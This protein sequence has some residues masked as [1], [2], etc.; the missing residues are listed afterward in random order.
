MTGIW[1]LGDYKYIIEVIIKSKTEA[2]QIL[3]KELILNVIANLRN[4][5]LATDG[6]SGRTAMYSHR[7]L[8]Q[9]YT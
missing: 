1:F 7:A 2:K 6:I 3:S 8:A 9:L 5:C 4:S